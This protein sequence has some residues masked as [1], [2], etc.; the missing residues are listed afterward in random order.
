MKKFLKIV[1][2][3]ILINVQLSC[4]NKEK[5][6]GGEEKA[7]NYIT[8]NNI[9][10]DTILLNFN[11]REIQVIFESD[12]IFKWNI[13]GDQWKDFQTEN[14]QTVHLSNHS[15]ITTWVET[16]TDGD[17][18]TQFVD[19]KTNVVAS[20]IRK[21]DGRVFTVSGTISKND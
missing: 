7:K 19:F 21:I 9:L 18:I 5:E 12:S 13:V 6:S 15:I 20:V 3:G 17:H 10:K 11:T 16:E 2:I 4:S 14:S 1:L 8:Y